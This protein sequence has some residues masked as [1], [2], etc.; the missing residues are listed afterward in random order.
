MEFETNE[1]YTY[2]EKYTCNEVL[3]EEKPIQERKLT[4]KNNNCV[5]EIIYNIAL[6]FEYFC[7]N[8]PSEQNTRDGSNTRLCDKLNSFMLDVFLKSQKNPNIFI[9]IS[10]SSFVTAYIYMCRMVRALH[11]GSSGARP[12]HSYCYPEM[13]K[14]NF[15]VALYIALKMNEDYFLCNIHT[16]LQH[17][18]QNELTDHVKK[19]E[20][21]FLYHIRFN[22]H[23]SREQYENTISVLLN[24]HHY[25][26]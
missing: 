21:G 16:F 7:S 20:L 17:I 6:H 4:P 19:E 26:K 14:S 8:A 10:I 25:H 23:V 9:P 24:E 2:N 3:F 15:V 1:E 5:F 13:I 11:D 12:S 18:G 22:T